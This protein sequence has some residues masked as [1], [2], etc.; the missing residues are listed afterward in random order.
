[1]SLWCS[2]RIA[3]RFGFEAVHQY[4]IS[5]DDNKYVTYRVVCTV[6]FQLAAIS[7]HNLNQ[8]IMRTSIWPGFFVIESSPDEGES[9]K[10][11]SKSLAVSRDPISAL[12]RESHGQRSSDSLHE[13]TTVSALD[14]G[15]EVGR[16]CHTSSI[17]MRNKTRWYFILYERNFR[18]NFSIRRILSAV[19]KK[20]YK[21]LG[22]LHHGTEPVVEKW[23]P[24]ALKNKCV[25]TPYYGLRQTK[26]LRLL[27]I[28]HLHRSHILKPLGVFLNRRFRH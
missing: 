25:G 8:R 28:I 11:D 10:S 20:S 9:L 17:F 1:M 13:K 18:S 15:A 5:L 16:I 19:A 14:K 2:G 4:L 22:R 3:G 12:Q 6:H 23:R 21:P 24:M 27:E 7:E 26:S